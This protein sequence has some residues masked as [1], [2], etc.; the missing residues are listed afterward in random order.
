MIPS[1]D[2]RS[3]SADDVSTVTSR[4]GQALRQLPTNPTQPQSSMRTPKTP[5]QFSRS[6]G[7]KPAVRFL[8]RPRQTVD[9][10]DDGSSKGN[11]SKGLPAS[12][13]RGRPKPVDVHQNDYTAAS[14]SRPRKETEQQ[15][16]PATGRP[17]A[18]LGKYFQKR[19]ALRLLT[20]SLPTPVLARVHEAT[21]SM[22]GAH[23]EWD[24]DNGC[25]TKCWRLAL[26]GRTDFKWCLSDWKVAGC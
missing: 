8:H 26:R 18:I 20:S 9:E 13:K 17:I 3:S 24:G 25:A 1:D 4:P 22:Y 19:M 23:S 21:E 6:Q 10:G 5:R 16:R 11:Q 2:E 7:V 12:R 14:P 15:G